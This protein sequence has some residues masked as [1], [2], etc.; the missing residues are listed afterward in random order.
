M[1]GKRGTLVP[2][3]VTPTTREL[4]EREDR[5]LPE[6]WRSY[7]QV[8]GPR[9]NRNKQTAKNYRRCEQLTRPLGDRPNVETVELFA[10]RLAETEWAPGRRYDPSTVYLHI[11]I[12]GSVYDLAL[13]RG[14]TPTDPVKE[15]RERLARDLPQKG[16]HPIRNIRELWPR[17]LAV[18]RDATEAAW[19]GTYRFGGLRPEEAPALLPEDVNT[20][21]RTWELFVNK[22]RLGWNSLE[23]KAPK[24]RRPRVV[25]VRPELRALLEPVLAAWRP[26][27][28]RFGTRDMARGKTECRFLFPYR[29]GDERDLRARLGAVAPEH[30]GPGH[31]LHTFR[32]TLA[33]ELYTGSPP[34]QVSTI[35]EW[36][37][38]KT[39]MTTEKYLARM[40]GGRVREDPALAQFFGAFE[41][42]VVDGAKFNGEA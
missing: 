34:V 38:H 32:H 18:A 20:R 7:W 14:W 26:V 22:Q 9:L 25:P 5:P 10:A 40:V 42:V 2:L 8:R 6:L 12:L 27:Q 13:R 15:V 17:F 23:T 37:G 29:A 19:L 28:L 11:C 36:L 41:T 24:Y 39:I 1:D 35:S 30:F 3:V 31:A 4:V 21:G 33:Y 16:S